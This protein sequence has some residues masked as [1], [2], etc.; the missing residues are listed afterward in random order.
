MHSKEAFQLQTR[1]PLAAYFLRYWCFNLI[2]FCV[3]ALG[4]WDWVAII[5]SRQ[6]TKIRK[7]IH[8]G[9]TLLM[10]RRWGAKRCLCFCDLSWRTLKC[11][12]QFIDICKKDQLIIRILFI[13]FPQSENA[14]KSKWWGNNQMQSLFLLLSI[15]QVVRQ[16]INTTVKTQFCCSF[17]K[18]D[19]WG[20]YIACRETTVDTIN[21]VK[22]LAMGGVHGSVRR[23]LGGVAWWGRRRALL[24]PHQWGTAYLFWVV[25]WRRWDFSCPALIGVGSWGPGFPVEC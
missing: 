5:W 4:L 20:I 11:Q 22:G 18:H 8:I 17:Q 16:S 9:C 1:L 14:V 2:I 21:R 10:L 3:F 25:R 12:K 23:A 6:Q 19:R 24:F 13:F 7:Q 15:S